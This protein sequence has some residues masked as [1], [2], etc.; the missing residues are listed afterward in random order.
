VN[1]ARR[2]MMRW[3]EF[4]PGPTVDRPFIIAA[5]VWLAVIPSTFSKVSNIDQRAAPPSRHI[6]MIT[7]LPSVTG[8][9]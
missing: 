8:V 3:K 4:E 6:P 1:D 9:R 2:T 5:V 7:A